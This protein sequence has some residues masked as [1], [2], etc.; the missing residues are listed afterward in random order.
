MKRPCTFVVIC[1]PPEAAVAIH[2]AVCCR[3]HLADRLP[4]AMHREASGF[5]HLLGSAHHS[6]RAQNDSHPYCKL[7]SRHDL[8]PIL[9]F[10][11][12][13]MTVSASRAVPWRKAALT[14]Q[15]IG[16]GG[17]QNTYT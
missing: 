6:R 5:R 2:A 10:A 11:R 14:D 1:N 16:A 7:L 4:T 8:P 9:R 15:R 12:L 3:R 13:E 17:L